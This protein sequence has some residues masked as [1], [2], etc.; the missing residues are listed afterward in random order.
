[1]HPIYILYNLHLLT[2]YCLNQT[3]TLQDGSSLLSY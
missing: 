2:K 1:M 3:G